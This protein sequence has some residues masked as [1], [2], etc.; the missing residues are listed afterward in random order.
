M[1][2]SENKQHTHKLTHTNA[3]TTNRHKQTNE[4]LLCVRRKDQGNITEIGPELCTYSG[5]TC[6]EVWV[7]KWSQPW[8]ALGRNCPGAAENSGKKSSLL[9]LFRFTLLLFFFSFKSV[10]HQWL[11]LAPTQ[12]VCDWVRGERRILDSILQNGEWGSQ[13]ISNAGAG[14]WLGQETLNT[15]DFS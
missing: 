3:W 7:K 6:W 5:S 14:K 4:N 11:Q 13:E 1:G 10:Y 12:G 2:S 9:W 15:D 8:K